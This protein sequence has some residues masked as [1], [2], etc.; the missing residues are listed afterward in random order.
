M[1]LRRS[2]NEKNILKKIYFY[3]EGLRLRSY[4]KKSLKK[5]RHHIVCSDIDKKRLLDLDDELQISVIPNGVELP[6]FPPTRKPSDKP[7]LLFVGGLN[8]YPNRD[9]IH[10]FLK[11]I[12][13]MIKAKFPNMTINIVGKSPSTFMLNFNSKDSSVKLHGFV[14]NIK[15]FYQS[16]T[17]YV[18]PIRDGGG[19]KLKIVDAL[20][21]KVP[22]VSTSVACE[23]I[24]VKN[25]RDVLFADSPSMF[26]QQIEKI[27]FDSE[28]SLSLAEN[29]YKLV[30]SKYDFVSIGEKLSSLYDSLA[31]RI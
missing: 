10:Y 2:R 18:C 23:G 20:A 31:L 15:P 16:A 8:W 19:T 30:R 1:M 3:Q 12:W 14:D 24:E 6:N 9:A 26:T 21:N 27:L 4:E 7:S 13:P 22:L 25:G 5:F 11:E 29:G 28:K 17:A